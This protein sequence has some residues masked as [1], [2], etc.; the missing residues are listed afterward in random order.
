MPAKN[1]YPLK[2][3]LRNMGLKMIFTEGDGN[4]LLHALIKSTEYT[5]TV[6]NLRKDLLTI[7]KDCHEKVKQDSYILLLPDFVVRNGKHYTIKQWRDYY[8]HMAVSRTWCD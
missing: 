2:V 4:C 7:V 6:E 5:G 3:R 1:A 8:R